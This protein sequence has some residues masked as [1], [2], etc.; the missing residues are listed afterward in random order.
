MASCISIDTCRWCP[1]KLSLSC[2]HKKPPT[3]GDADPIVFMY[4]STQ[5]SNDE[6]CVL[7]SGFASNTN[8]TPQLS[9]VADVSD[10]DIMSVNN[11]LLVLSI[12]G[13]RFCRNGDDAAGMRGKHV[14]TIFQGNLLRVIVSLVTVLQQTGRH[15]VLQT[16]YG[17]RQALT[18]EAFGIAS[19]SGLP[20]KRVR[21]AL[22]G[23][24]VVYRPTLYEAAQLSASSE[25]A[26][27]SESSSES[28]DEEGSDSS[29]TSSDN[30]ESS[31]GTLPPTPCA[32][33]TPKQTR[34]VSTATI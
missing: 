19:D 32:H 5:P 30:K 15:P 18:M 10:W 3:Q 20:G 12:G 16:L 21:R 17:G 24:T 6:L 9:D 22:I 23:T 25:C 31:D 7:S 2:C 13:P 27:S 33:S 8:R 4:E 28:S 1:D 29:C 11:D 34:D 26:I 14:N